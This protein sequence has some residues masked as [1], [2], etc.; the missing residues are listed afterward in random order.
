M[1]AI[2]PDHIGLTHLVSVSAGQ[3]TAVGRMTG[4]DSGASVVREAQALIL[5]PG[6]RGLA[7]HLVAAISA[8]EAPIPGLTSGQLVAAAAE[9]RAARTEGAGVAGWSSV[10]GESAIHHPNVDGEA[11][12]G[13]WSAAVSPATT[14]TAAAAIHSSA[15]VSR[16]ATPAICAPAPAAR[17]SALGAAEEVGARGLVHLCGGVLA[18]ALNLHRQLGAAGGER[19]TR[20]VPTVD[21]S[22]PVSPTRTGV[23]P[24]PIE[25]EATAGHARVGG[26]PRVAR[27]CIDGRRHAA[28][29]SGGGG[30]RLGERRDVR[31]GQGLAPYEGPSAQ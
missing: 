21:G 5:R 30:V 28:V 18:D 1:T 17:A 10:P 25:R 13:A 7:D 29:R 14:I 16:G 20:P 15:S 31:L 12:V 2:T 9:G 8:A 6:Y 27:A 3:I 4:A 24:T 23:A 19:P 11:G 26:A 22:A